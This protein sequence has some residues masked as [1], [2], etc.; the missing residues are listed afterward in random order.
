[1]SESRIAE[2][3]ATSVVGLAQE[4]GLLESLKD[5]MHQLKSI[6][7]SSRDFIIM[8][9][10]PIIGN[11]KKL[12]ILRAIFKDANELTV[13]FLDL[14]TRKNRSRVLYEVSLEVIKQYNAIKG[15]QQ[16]VVTTAVEIS[17]ELKAR[18]E[19]A[20]KQIS[21]KPLVDMEYKVEEKLIGG[22]VLSVGD[23]RLDN[24]IH[25]GLSRLRTELTV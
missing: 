13:K 10:S 9:K 15:I 18:F 20:V 8:L 2:R 22:F 19:D 5:D 12:S 17:P 7:E 3:Y 6:C 23:R 11:S 21:Q 14:V 1:M 24:S 25:N 16:A 4:K